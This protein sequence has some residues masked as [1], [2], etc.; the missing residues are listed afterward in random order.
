MKMNIKSILHVTRVVY[1]AYE[2]RF[3][4]NET[5]IQLSEHLVVF[6][7][8]TA[9]RFSIKFALFYDGEFIAECYS[10]TVPSAAT[11][12]NAKAVLYTKHDTIIIYNIKNAENNFML[13]CGK[14][15]NNYPLNMTEEQFFQYSTVHDIGIQLDDIHGI[16]KFCDDVQINQAMRV[17]NVS[18]IPSVHQQLFTDELNKVSKYLQSIGES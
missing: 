13:R 8:T 15:S 17:S 16:N 18:T 7:D 1:Q 9:S 11:M 12:L 6:L 5:C 14:F 4:I 3:M 2:K 10:Y